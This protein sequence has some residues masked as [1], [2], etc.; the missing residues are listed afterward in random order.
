MARHRWSLPSRKLIEFS[1]SLVAVVRFRL[2]KYVMCVHVV[3]ARAAARHI[4]A[5]RKSNAELL[6]SVDL[7][8]VHVMTFD[9][10]RP[11]NWGQRDLSVQHRSLH[12]NVAAAES[13]VQI[14]TSA[15][16]CRCAAGLHA[17]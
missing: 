8:S 3:A 4:F 9:C 5:P 10:A 2:Y 13:L 16:P 7:H 6:I 11:L 14:S 15:E 1:G 12:V 17:Y